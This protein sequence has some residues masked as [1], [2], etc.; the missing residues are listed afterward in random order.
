MAKFRVMKC[1]D[2]DRCGNV[3]TRYYIQEKTVFWQWWW[4]RWSSSCEPGQTWFDTLQAATDKV[5]ELVEQIRDGEK[6]GEEVVYSYDTNTGV[7]KYD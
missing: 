1:V 5:D 3:R 7:V 6:I 4:E 2:R